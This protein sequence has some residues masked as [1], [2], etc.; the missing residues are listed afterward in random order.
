MNLAERETTQDRRRIIMLDDNEDFVAVARAWLSP[1]HTF[2]GV[3]TV[4]DFLSRLELFKPDLIILDVQMPDSD[5][6]T[7]CSRLH[8]LRR[9]DNTPILFVT[10]SKDVKDCARGFE[11]GGS[12][13]LRKP[14]TRPELL[15]A[16]SMIVPTSTERA[17]NEKAMLQA[18]KSHL[19][20]PSTNPDSRSRRIFAGGCDEPKKR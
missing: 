20:T 8:S 1:W 16:I 6:I 2:L 13:Y 9:C 4:V 11:A 7:V 15:C 17:D 10:A 12:F 5:G 18:L 3:S 14:V 19:M